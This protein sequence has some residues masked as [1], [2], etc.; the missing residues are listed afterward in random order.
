VKICPPPLLPALLMCISSAAQAQ[1]PA[2]IKWAAA[3]EFVTPAPT[4]VSLAPTH[5]AAAARLSPQPSHWVEGGVIGAIALGGGL[6]LLVHGL[7]DSDAGGT[8][9]CGDRTVGALVLGGAAGFVVGALIGGT[10][11]RGSP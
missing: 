9:S 2:P 4:G 5:P 8:S 6:G 7:C 11:P 1:G 10:I 3:M